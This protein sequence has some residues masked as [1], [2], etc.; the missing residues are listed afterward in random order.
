MTQRQ[1]DWQLFAA[2][3]WLIGALGGQWLIT[4]ASHPDA[5]TINVV[6]AWGQLI[7]GVALGIWGWRRANLSGETPAG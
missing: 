4:P 6:A 2:F 7:G 5:G 1:R 3:M